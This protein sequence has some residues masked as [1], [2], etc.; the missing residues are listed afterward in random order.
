MAIF[1]GSGGVVE[2]FEGLARDFL[3]ADFMAL[4]GLRRPSLPL[5]Y[6][7]IN[8]QSGWDCAV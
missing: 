1:G 2:G 5:F 3:G 4:M 6:A 7:S 8:Q